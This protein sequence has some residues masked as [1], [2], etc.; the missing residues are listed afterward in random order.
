MTPEEEAAQRQADAAARKNAALAA[1]ANTPAPVVTAQPPPLAAIQ[2]N[3][4]PP[5]GFGGY[6]KTG[7]LNASVNAPAS[8]S[9]GF[10]VTPTAARPVTQQ[11]NANTQ[12]GVLSAADRARI[13]QTNESIATARQA[14]DAATLAAAN[15]KGNLDIHATQGD[16]DARNAAIEA[17]R[18]LSNASLG[19]IRNAQINNTT[20]STANF[21]FNEQQTAARQ[22]GDQAL[23]D[24]QS[25]KQS[26]IDQA[27]GGIPNIAQMAEADQR[28]AKAQRASDV[29]DIN[30]QSA[31]GG[32]NRIDQTANAG[33]ISGLF[34]ATKDVSNFTAGKVDQSSL[35]GDRA[36]LDALTNSIGGQ[37]F[38]ATAA[39]SQAAKSQAAKSQAAV[40]DQ[41]P[42]N[43]IRDRQAG[44]ADILTQS[45]NGQGPSAAQAQ[46][47]AGTDAS[48]SSALALAH[49]G[50][51]GS[52]SVAMKNALMQNGQTMQ[53]ASNQAAQLR[54]QEQQQARGQLAGVLDS[55]RGAD[56]GVAT[57][58]AGL[59]QGAALQNSAQQ[60]QTAIANAANQQQTGL[61][62][63]ANQQQTSLAN[64]DAAFKKNDAIAKLLAQGFSQD[65][66][67]HAADIQEA[68]FNADLLA[69]QEAA[70]NGEAL[71]AGQAQTN[72]LGSAISTAGSVIASASDRRVKKNI[73]DGEEATRKFL[74]T[75]HP[76]SFEYTDEKFGKG[77]HLGVMAQD[78]EKSPVDVVFDDDDGV[79]KLDIRKALSASLASL[80]S[81]DKRLGKMERKRG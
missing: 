59:N 72:A 22:A 65:Q 41:N 6:T 29:A 21:Q 11:A 39:T 35:Q 23:S 17:S 75:L 70:H 61:A 44:L 79:K 3:A 13:A 53:A 2:G 81:L 46:L 14:S 12:S 10:S 20:D 66:A 25:Y 67:T 76:K 51:G 28:I 71:A 7:A 80:G 73:D 37:N 69:R 60:Q 8:S 40:I 4:K 26:I 64:Q 74:A 57:S 31:N 33:G 36:N 19:G 27:H 15:A 55:S 18:N 38:D 78:V 30:A 42:Q 32:V 68:Q 49:S 5:T 63:A 62:N 52:S 9:G 48:I 58:Q 77:P 1:S 43:Q 16:A 50:R 34:G 24:A 54:A 45:A 56:I 47:Q